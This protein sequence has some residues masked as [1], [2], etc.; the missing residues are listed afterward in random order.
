MKHV[1]RSD[2][3]LRKLLSLPPIPM[4]TCKGWEAEEAIF[5]TVCLESELH[6]SS[7]SGI[8]YSAIVMLSI[9]CWH[10]GV[11]APTEAELENVVTHS[12]LRCSSG[13]LSSRV[14]FRFPISNR[15][16]ISCLCVSVS[17]SCLGL[18]VCGVIWFNAIGSV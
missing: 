4:T 6:M 12:L 3:C 1:L 15:R 18:E 2:G 11:W 8:G 5:P 9:P 7:E 17:T 10:L 16:P 14:C 13:K